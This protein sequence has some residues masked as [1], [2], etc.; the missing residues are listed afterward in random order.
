MTRR[1]PKMSRGANQKVGGAGP[2][3]RGTCQPPGPL[4]RRIRS[5]LATRTSATPR[6]PARFGRPDRSRGGSGRSWRPEFPQLH[7]NRYPSTARTARAEDPVAPSDQGFRN[8]TPT[9]AFQPPGPLTRRIRFLQRPEGPRRPANPHPPAAR[10]A[11]TED[12][13]APSDQEFRNVPQ[14]GTFRP[15]ESLARRIR[16]PP[17][18]QSSAGAT[19]HDH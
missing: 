8:S 11:R 18:T 5:L 14:T 13:V 10:T 15:S 1:R 2:H 19:A 9:G 4:T 17:A 6:E 12:P 7:A 3:L 16:S